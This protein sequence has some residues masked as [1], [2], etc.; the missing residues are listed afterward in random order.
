[1]ILPG[2]TWG[3]GKGKAVR[4]RH[5]WISPGAVDRI[6]SGLSEGDSA[7]GEKV[8]NR[9]THTERIDPEGLLFMFSR[10]GHIPAELFQKIVFG[11]AEDIGRDVRIPEKIGQPFD[12]PINIRHPEDECFEGLLS[13]IARGRKQNAGGGREHLPRRMLWGQRKRNG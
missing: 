8:L 1:M 7:A 10:P 6:D 2:I 13:E 9:F 3:Q 12:H 11:A 4:N 5:P